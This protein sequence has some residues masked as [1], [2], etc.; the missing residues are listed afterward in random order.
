M[1]RKLA[2]FRIQE[3]GSKGKKLY[4]W[5]FVLEE[6]LKA[7]LSSLALYFQAT[8]LHSPH[9][10]PPRHRVPEQQQINKIAIKAS[11]AIAKTAI[12]L[13]SELSRV[14]VTVMDC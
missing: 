2:V 12:L 5:G 11:E 10:L 14:F 1:C 7:L 13:I 4:H 8:Y 3:V 9:A 6:N